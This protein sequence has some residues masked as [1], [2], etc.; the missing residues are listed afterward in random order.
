[1]GKGF[2]HFDLLT[3]NYIYIYLLIKTLYFVP[4]ILAEHRETF[5]CNDNCDRKANTLQ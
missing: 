2:P 4:D 1:M 5:Y 3:Y